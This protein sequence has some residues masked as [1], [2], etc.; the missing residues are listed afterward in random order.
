[1]AGAPGTE[2]RAGKK[3][4]PWGAI[5]LYGALFAIFFAAVLI[6][7]RIWFTI[8]DSQMNFHGWFAMGLGVFFSLVIGGGLMA[9]VFYSSRKGYDDEVQ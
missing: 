8:G 5:L 6:A 2:E 7:I 4:P 1:M 3:G 9:L